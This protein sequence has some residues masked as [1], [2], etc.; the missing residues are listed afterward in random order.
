M[1]AAA[2]L[3]ILVVDDQRSMR[4]LVRE[5]LQTFGVTQITECQDGLEA[6]LALE[7]RPRNLII[8][9]LNMPKMDGLGLLRAVRGDPAIAKTAFIML[10]SR[11]EA[12][13]VQEAVKLGVNNYL[14]KPFTMDTLRKKV[15]AVVGRLT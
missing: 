11:A 4:V 1:P 6:L 5:S 2:S 3:S 10:T 13:L 15:E 14:V 7:L 12:N 9:D 8:S